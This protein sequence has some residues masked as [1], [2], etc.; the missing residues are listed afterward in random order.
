MYRTGDLVCWGADGQLAYLGRADEQVKI[1]GY[2]VELGEIQAA[3]TGLD[4]VKQAVVIAREDRPGDKR[5]VGYVV[6]VTG[7]LD[8]AGIRA[9]LA[10]RLPAYMVPAAVVVVDTLP[11]TPNGKLDK[12]ALPAPEYTDVDRYRAPA[13]PVEEILAG[14][15]ARVL[16][17]ERVGVDDSFFD[18]GGDSLSAMRVIAAINTSLDTHLAVHTLFFAPSVRRLSQ[19]LGPHANAVE[20]VPVEV[21]KEGT[22]VP[23]CC[24]H[25]GF[26]LSW[27]YRALGNYLDCPIIGINQ[28]PQNGEPE[29]ASIR[30]MAASYADRLQAVYPAGP[31]KLL[32]WSFGGV[33][34]HELAIELQR[35]GC[36]VQ[37]LVLLDVT[38]I[39]KMIAGI[40][41]NR[42]IARSQALAKSQVLEYI[43]RT[44]G[45][46]IP[47][48]LRTLTYRQV[49]ELI[50]QREAVEFGLPPQPLFQFMVHSANINQHYLL[51]HS[52]DVFDGDV[53][54]FSA[55]RGLRT[56]S[57]WRR[58]LTRMVAR[59]SPQR[60]RRYVAGNIT[61]YSIE[62]THY[63][64]LTIRRLNMYG[65]Q[66]NILLE[67]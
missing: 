65:E 9:A 63:E 53:V 51:K 39:A 25:D 40:S 48:Q 7:R 57:P 19:Q 32:G 5:L 56:W 59:S 41:A 8:P 66:L 67:T 44:N 31:Y 58:L 15:Y 38:F 4:G 35:R 14:I 36:E 18:L 11:L 54:I 47:T 33:V 21:I 45:I 3:L 61:A 13:T 6:G 16:G 49:E 46:D 37:R 60:W 62:C 20:V 26:G 43:L 1:R 22:G 12:R 10:Q 30:S 50:H 23:L 52:P 24:I 42:L 34:A 64:M 2:R 28:I 29:P 27:S 55:A 17:L